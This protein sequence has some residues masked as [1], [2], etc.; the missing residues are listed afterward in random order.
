MLIM[1]NHTFFNVKSLCTSKYISIDYTFVTSV[2]IGLSFFV[3]FIKEECIFVIISLLQNTPI[4][5]GLFRK[6]S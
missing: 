4:Y 1:E 5:V 6:V 3:H 2:I